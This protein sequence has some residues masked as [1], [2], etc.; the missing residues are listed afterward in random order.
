MAIEGRV[1]GRP[2]KDNAVLLRIDS[3]QKIT[4]VLLDCG[5]GILAGLPVSECRSVDILLLSHLHFDH[6]CG[7]DSLLRHIYKRDEPFRIWGPDGTVEAVHH[8]LRGFTWNLL[9]RNAPGKF[10][11]H[12]VGKSLRGAGM[13]AREKFAQASE[14]GTRPF[15]GIAFKC[16]EFTIRAAIVDHHIP[17]LAYTVAEGP[18]VTIDKESM[19]ELG[20]EPGPWCARLKDDSLADDAEIDAG[21]R[22]RL[23]ELR[24]SLLRSRPGMKVS[25]LTD[26]FLTPE[27]EA[28]LL[29]MMEGSSL[30]FA[31]CSYLASEEPLALEHRHLTTERI[32]R[33]AKKAR[34]GELVLMHVSDR[35]RGEQRRELLREVREI[36]PQAR[37]PEEWRL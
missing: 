10:L 12:D 29:P 17:C 31:E 24:R 16:P 25:Y 9:G 34:A 14:T 5:E 33:F 1:L 7:F 21:G 13:L 26:L 27:E 19:R 22:R 20:L 15:A 32:A 37:F 35:Y 11:V 6:I 18:S 3:G 23:G 4:R 2:D 28:R 30:L 36:F 8:R